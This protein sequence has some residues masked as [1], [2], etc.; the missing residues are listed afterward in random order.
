M[1]AIFAWIEQTPLSIFMREDLWAFPVTLILH[2][3]GMGM[4]AGGGM[5]MGLRVLG[6]AKG[7]RLE[8]F[9]KFIPVMQA[10]FWLAFVTGLLLL[11]AYPAKALTNWVFALKFV[12]LGAAGLLV[13]AMAKRVL[14]AGVASPDW[15]RWVAGASLVA[16]AGAITAGRFLAYTNHMLLVT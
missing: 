11:S 3:V 14:P 15:A 6:V 4:L 8:L 16:W 1:I 2:S 13:R 5:V 9:A 12:M 10:G 7:A